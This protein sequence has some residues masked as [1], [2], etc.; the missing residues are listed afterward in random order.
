M[1]WRGSRAP[2]NRTPPEAMAAQLDQPSSLGE[3]AEAE[4]GCTRC[5]LYRDATQVVPGEGGIKAKI[6]FV[7]EQP[8]D[9]EDRT[10]RPFVGPAGRLF[11][12]ALQ[13]AG[14]RRSDVFVT[15]AV[16]HFKFQMRGKRR[17]HSKPNAYEIE[18]CRWWLDLERGLLRPRL[19]VALGATAARALLG[20]SVTLR[21]L[22]GEAL[23]LEEDVRLLVTL[24]PSALLRMRDAERREAAYKDFVGELEKAHDIVKL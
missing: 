8:G 11:D 16:K 5:P 15:N 23:F 20:R 21:S 19:I 13:D 3:L 14:L 2:D 4:A 12:R 1:R 24:H 22:R 17:L 7:G 6:M 9:H 18:R 10:G